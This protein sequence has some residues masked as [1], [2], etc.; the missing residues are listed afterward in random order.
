MS[1]S[2]A[3]PEERAEYTRLFA[4]EADEALRLL[5]EGLLAL[6]QNPANKGLAQGPYRAAHT[7]KGSAAYLELETIRAL[8]QGLEQPLRAVA[9]G[10]TAFAS[11]DQALLVQAVERLY[12]LVQRVRQGQSA[13]DPPR[14]RS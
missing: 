14:P 5:G 2:F 10:R 12:R 7:L 6:R 8:A 3:S 13:A 9:E 4:E 1:L 11:L